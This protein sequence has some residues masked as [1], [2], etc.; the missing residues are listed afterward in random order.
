M[1]DKLVSPN[2]TGNKGNTGPTDASQKGGSLVSPNK[3]TASS[4]A[5]GHDNGR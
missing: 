3:S 1:G 5:K 2:Q 4:E